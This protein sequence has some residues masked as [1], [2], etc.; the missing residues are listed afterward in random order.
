MGAAWI[1]PSFPL[2]HRAIAQKYKLHVV[3]ILYDLIPYTYPDFV[4]AD[5][6]RE[7]IFYI[8][9][10]LSIS[11]A[12]ISISKYVSD[13]LASHLDSLGRD[14]VVSP[15]N[16]YAELAREIPFKV[17][18]SSS[19]TLKHIM[20]EKLLS[21]GVEVDN[22]ILN[23]G[24]VEIR[25]NHITLF[26][27]WRQLLATLG[28]KCPQLIVVGRPGWKAESFFES[29]KSTNNLDGKLIILHGI[30]D[31]LLSYL[32]ETCKLTIYP[33]LEEGWGLP[34]GESLDAGKLCI[35]SNRASMP[36]VGKELCYYV[37]PSNPLEIVKE[38]E[39]LLEYP[40]LVKVAEKKILASLPLKSWGEY[41]SEIAS[42]ISTIKL[43]KINPISKMPAVN[44]FLSSGQTVAF[45]WHLGSDTYN[46]PVGLSGK[47]RSLQGLL[48]SRIVLCTKID[49]F[50]PDGAWCKEPMF[51]LSFYIDISEVKST[52]FSVTLHYHLNESIDLLKTLEI[53]AKCIIYFGNSTIDIDNRTLKKN[54]FELIAKNNSPNI[55]F[56]SN[57]LVKFEFEN[58][59][60]DHYK[61][62]IDSLN[63]KKQR[64]FL[65]I[66]IVVSWT[67]GFN[68]ICSLG[69]ELEP[70]KIKEILIDY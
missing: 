37:N 56:I 60:I 50:E 64:I 32:Y 30:D 39:K 44:W 31:A 48:P 12:L 59:A 51:E 43:K 10:L 35:T 67:P 63:I 62:L 1:V 16:Y 49:R 26:V 11:D 54:N 18:E 4:S 65:P 69:R 34:I 61:T 70:V 58:V 47:N 22:F 68:F 28:N 21:L 55:Y 33:S 45:Y 15:L 41:L 27:A 53:N 29:L 20:R 2:A 57:D 9:S 24:S 17:L 52:K 6:S 3:S 38:I 7:F 23:V 13:D 42:L 5:A 66:N 8:N 40:E 46:L 36:E 25:K 19:A 14:L